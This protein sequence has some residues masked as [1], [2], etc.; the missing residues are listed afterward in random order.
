M[1]SNGALQ[2]LTTAYQE[3]KADRNPSISQVSTG[4]SGTF[5]DA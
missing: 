5:T 1:G 2:R 4:R 3:S